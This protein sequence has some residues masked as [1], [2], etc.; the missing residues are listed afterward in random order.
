MLHQT[1]IIIAA[2]ALLLCSAPIAQAQTGSASA[3]KS[4]IAMAEDN[5]K[6]ER[7]DLVESS[8]QQAEK[9]LEG[10]PA[11]EK[12]PLVKKI[13]E[14]RAAVEPAKKEIA[15]RRLTSRIESEIRTLEEDVLKQVSSVP[16]R[17]AAARAKLRT[18]EV[19]STLEEAAIEKFKTRL[20]DVL[21][22]LDKGA[23]PEAPKASA[24]QAR[25]RIM[26]A[27]SAVESRRFEN[28][29]AYLEQA[30]GFLNGLPETEKAPLLKDIDEIRAALKEGEKAERLRIVESRIDRYIR[31][32]EGNAASDPVGS[33]DMLKMTR[34]FLATREVTDT[35][36]PARIGEINTRMAEA[37]KL[38]DAEF[39]QRAVRRAE[40][41][42]RELEEG[43]ANDPYAG[44]NE[45]DAYKASRHLE[46]LHRAIAMAFDNIPKDD[47]DVRAVLAKAAECKKKMESASSAWSQAQVEAA[48]KSGW[49]FA[50][51]D[52]DGWREETPDSKA[53]PNEMW[54]MQKT[55]LALRSSAYWLADPQFVKL[56]ADHGSN[57]VVKA[58]FAEAE[59]TRDDAAA[60]L[61]E[62]FNSALAIAEKLP[63]P[64][65]ATRFDRSIAPW[66]KNDADEIFKGTRFQAA[67]VA[68]AKALDD[69]W[70]KEIEALR[71]AAAELRAKYAK[72]AAAAWPAI[73]DK[74]QP[75]A[76][77]DAKRLARSK[78][79]TIIMKRIY[80][81]TG[82]DFGGDYDFTV[83]ING[84][85]IGGNFEKPIN[86]GIQALWE[87]MNAP[88]LDSWE[89]W[90]VIAVVEG[91][92]KIRRRVITEII[93][94]ETREVIGKLEGHEQEDGV[95]VRIIGLLAGPYVGSS[96]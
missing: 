74:L 51:Q 19:R 2:L 96:K 92:A 32:A 53:K 69:R 33:T 93:S 72:E 35:L 84:V 71:K 61:N 56:R 47:P 36:T 6:S 95:Q 80:N 8:L 43:L 41:F 21:K 40:D 39:K 4:R 31:S 59:K 57:A 17:V 1:W 13:A 12:D 87:K 14:V 55:V 73:V 75:D 25:S 34:D 58:T 18:Q 85:A 67:N 52:A 45:F 70:E 37:Q 22:K 81:R 50:M 76:D 28:V 77:F 49:Q 48:V 15:A 88:P 79:D 30:L 82:W 66:M 7:F 3:A 46:Y 5:L 86:D 91:P 27:R 29:E 10:L 83:R 63:T 64:V 90:D 62:A 20:D 26:Q 68:R 24:S 54:R 60:K 23:Q 78:G 11:A 94:A 42:L 89:E 44:L 38:I 16:D 9:Y 65:G